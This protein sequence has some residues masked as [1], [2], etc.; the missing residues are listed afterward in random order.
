M[1]A[2]ERDA[3]AALLEK[4]AKERSIIIIEHDMDFVESLNC[5]VTVLNEGMVLAEGTMDVLKKNKEV[6]DVYL[7]R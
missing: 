5:P 2:K 3:T 6:I 1:T 7:G 4:I